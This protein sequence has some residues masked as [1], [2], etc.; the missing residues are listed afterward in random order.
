[1]DTMQIN[2]WKVGKN[3]PGR[4]HS[5]AQ[6]KREGAGHSPSSYQRKGTNRS[7]AAGGG[8]AGMKC[9]AAAGW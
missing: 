6:L 3:S 4:G 5:R 2:S 8:V 1:M 9:E 7:K